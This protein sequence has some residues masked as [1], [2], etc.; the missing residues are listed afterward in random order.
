MG[1]T[2]VMMLFAVEHPELQQ[3]EFSS[4]A[5]R[6]YDSDR[7]IHSPQIFVISCYY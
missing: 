7:S 4:G 6:I 1:W 3:D 2:G 5:S